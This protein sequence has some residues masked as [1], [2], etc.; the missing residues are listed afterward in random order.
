MDV[1]SVG[2][3]VLIEIGQV[4]TWKSNGG[5]RSLPKKGIVRA[6]I[7]PGK[8][9]SRVYPEL[10]CVSQNR[11]NFRSVSRVRRVLVEVPRDDRGCRHYSVFYAPPATTVESQILCERSE[12]DG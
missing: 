11:R 6:F 5:S 1:T 12:K 2:S 8:K 7:E 10:A 9:A 3:D 4:V